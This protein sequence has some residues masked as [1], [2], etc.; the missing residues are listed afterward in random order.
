MSLTEDS[1]VASSESS[2]LTSAPANH[3]KEVTK[4]AMVDSETTLFVEY[5]T[6]KER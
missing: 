5:L 2:T 6:E 4:F 1:T 3:D